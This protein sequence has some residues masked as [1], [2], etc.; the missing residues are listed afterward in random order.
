MR[1]RAT[2]IDAPMGAAIFQK[3]LKNLV[4]CFLLNSY[5]KSKVRARVEHVFGAMTNE[6][7][8]IV[9]RVIGR[10]RATAK[11][12]LMNLVYNLKRFETI[13]RLRASRV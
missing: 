5:E 6:M 11:V 13:H 7:G 9:V 10:V 3:L 8:G 12:G 1:L 2:K 4:K